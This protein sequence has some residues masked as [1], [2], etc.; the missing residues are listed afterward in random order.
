MATDA[1][2]IIMVLFRWTFIQQQEQRT[3]DII[4]YSE[5]VSIY[6]LF[7]RLAVTI[8]ATGR[9]NMRMDV[10]VDSS[11]FPFNWKVFQAVK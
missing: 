7:D 1:L 9:Q 6:R 10:F 3:N 11:W 8:T 4:K 5:F 2:F